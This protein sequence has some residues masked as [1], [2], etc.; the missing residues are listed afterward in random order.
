MY[1]YIYVY[2]YIYTYIYREIWGAHLLVS[3]V[4]ELVPPLAQHLPERDPRL[5]HLK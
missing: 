2:V 1:I 4:D 5:A 3:Q